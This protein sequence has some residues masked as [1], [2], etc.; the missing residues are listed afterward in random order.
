MLQIKAKNH[1]SNVNVWKQ[2]NAPTFQIQSVKLIYHDFMQRCGLFSKDDN[3]NI[4][5]LLQLTNELLSKETQIGNF[6]LKDLHYY[7]FFRKYLFHLIDSVC[8]SLPHSYVHTVT[9][10]LQFWHVH[11]A[12]VLRQTQHIVNLSFNGSTLHNINNI[13]FRLLCKCCFHRRTL[14]YASTKSS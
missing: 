4:C 5:P 14:I 7:Y 1:Q 13:T 3:K 11:L 6:I 10:R 2:C 8:W 12:I 9:V